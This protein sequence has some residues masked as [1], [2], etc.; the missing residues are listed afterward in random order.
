MNFTETASVAY[1]SPAFA[2]EEYTEAN[3]KIFMLKYNSL[4]HQRE[5][6]H[7]HAWGFDLA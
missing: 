3:K 7:N 2:G 6:I 1:S 5:I 4:Q